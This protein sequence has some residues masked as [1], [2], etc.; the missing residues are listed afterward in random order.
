MIQLQFDDLSGTH[1]IT[2][3]STALLFVKVVLFL[4][5]LIITNVPWLN[6]VDFFFYS[7]A[8]RNFLCVLMSSSYLVVWLFNG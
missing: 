2:A 8:T 5:L 6:Y 4:M 7:F 1:F 3:F